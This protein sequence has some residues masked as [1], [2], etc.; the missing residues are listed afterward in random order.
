MNS[1]KYS[2]EYRTRVLYHATNEIED[3]V[4]LV[5]CLMVGMIV[6]TATLVMER[7]RKNETAQKVARKLA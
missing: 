4:W 3:L 1:I 5:A 6:G 7:N 2:T